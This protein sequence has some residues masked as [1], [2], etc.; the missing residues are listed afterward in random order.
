MSVFV[1]DDF[2]ILSVVAESVVVGPVIPDGQG[3]GLAF[4]GEGNPYGAVFQRCTA[5]VDAGQL[6]L[7]VF[8]HQHFQLAA[9]DGLLFG[10]LVVDVVSLGLIFGIFLEP[11]GLF[12]RFEFAASHFEYAVDIEQVAFALFLFDF[13]QEQHTLF[14]LFESL[15]VQ[16]FDTVDGISGTLV[17]TGLE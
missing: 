13:T 4:V 14:N 9:G 2:G 6:H 8:G 7:T 16:L 5:V 11:E 15:W 12:G 10:Q 3:L 1:G 17:L